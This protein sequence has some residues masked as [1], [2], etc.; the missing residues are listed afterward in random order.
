MRSCIWHSA[1]ELTGK[2]DYDMRERCLSRK[3]LEFA[4]IYFFE[5]QRIKG[6]LVYR[7][8]E[9]SYKQHTCMQNCSPVTRLLRQR[10]QCNDDEFICVALVPKYAS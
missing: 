5:F 9:H 10:A 4:Y 1:V 8:T 3:G 2:L 6:P 7:I